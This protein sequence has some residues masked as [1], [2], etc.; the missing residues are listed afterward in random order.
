L[1]SVHEGEATKGSVTWNG[2]EI[3]HDNPADIVKSG[4]TQVMEGESANR[5]V[6][7]QRQAV[8]T[9]RL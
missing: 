4:I 2:D 5:C 7:E 1:L 8:S 6:H 9:G 3:T